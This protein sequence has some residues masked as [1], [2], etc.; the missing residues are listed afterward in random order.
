MPQSFG[1]E[2]SELYSK[3][4][5]IPISKLLQHRRERKRDGLRLFC[6][7]ENDSVGEV[8]CM[9][10]KEGILAAP[11]WK[12]SEDVAGREY[13]G[14]ISVYDILAYT[15][16]QK[17]FDKISSP[18]SAKETAEPDAEQFTSLLEDVKES[19][20][21]FFSTPV[22]EIVGLTREGQQAWTIYS[23]NPVSNVLQLFT[24]G[25]NYHRVLILDEDVLNASASGR[26]DGPG[27]TAPPEGSS[28]TMITQTDLL[29]FILDNEELRPLLTKILQ[30]PASSLSITVTPTSEDPTQPSG[31]R[32]RRVIT[33]PD[34]FT[35][36]AAFRTMYTHRVS[37]VAI[38]A[39][40]GSLCANLSASDLRGISQSNIECLLDNVYTF[41]E[42]D[43]RRRDDQVKADQ[44]K[45]VSEVRDSNAD[46]QSIPTVGEV[47]DLM[48]GSRI[49]RVWIVD[50]DDRPTGVVTLSDILGC[51]IPEGG[52]AIEQ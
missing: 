3:L 35:A 21:Q 44:L 49:H 6:I 51:F 42:V 20:D 4:S 8:L 27:P 33:V 10:R 38:I 52:R 25:N 1:P 17:L 31:T 23:S 28:I 24:G 7:N 30:T 34:T 36:L 16:F 39:D 18:P 50:G 43:T 13:T 37:A 47:V 29:T 41:L 22:K 40:S 9:L 19:Q 12:Q 45:F 11:V 48:L 2:I 26:D 32:P 14:I 5:N 15:V 46:A